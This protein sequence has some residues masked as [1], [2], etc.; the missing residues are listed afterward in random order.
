MRRLLF[1]RFTMFFGLMS[2]LVLGGMAAAAFLLARVFGSGGQVAVLVWGLGCGLALALPALALFL[3]NRAFRGIA[4]PLAEVMSAAD[5]VAGGDLSVRISESGRG[6]F[7]RLARSFNRM[8]VELERGEQRRR[9]MTADIAHELRTPLHIIQGNLEGILDGIY[10]PTE[11]HVTA[12][13]EETHLLARLVDDL[14]TLALAEAGEL[15]LVREPLDMVELL[16][17]VRTSFS[18]QAEAAGIALRLEIDPELGTPAVT[19]DVDRI[20]QVLGNLVV[21]ALRHTPRGGQIILSAMP[22]E[23]GLRIQV[24]D[25]GEGIAADEIAY[26]FDRFWRGDPSRSRGSGSLGLGLAIAQQLVEAHGGKIAVES[27]PDRGTT[28][29]IELYGDGDRFTE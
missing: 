12:T 7:A 15:E 28:F 17:D 3:A 1:L 25:T 26:V 19:A 16:E 13:L 11:D 22:I 23:K 14:Q 24:S 6:D 27:E 9:N 8:T 10:K 29:S 21:N 18:G 4:T 5:A 20:D 2:A